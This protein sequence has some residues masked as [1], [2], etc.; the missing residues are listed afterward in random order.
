MDYLTLS[1]ILLVNVKF[2]YI[3]IK[4]WWSY[5]NICVDERTTC[6]KHFG[7]SLAALRDSTIV[8]ISVKIGI[9]LSFDILAGNIIA[10][11][12]LIPWKHCLCQARFFVDISFNEKYKQPFPTLR[13]RYEGEITYYV[14]FVDLN[15]DLEGCKSHMRRD[16]RHFCF[17]KNTSA[18]F[19]ILF[20]VYVPQISLR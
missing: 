14:N 18:F 20:A 10:S 12:S 5:S 4:R 16:A 7:I 8:I 2:N 11:T 9:S 6:V 1:R 19:L 15:P 13:W 3:H 17:S